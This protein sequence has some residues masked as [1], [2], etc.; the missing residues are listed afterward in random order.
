MMLSLSHTLNPGERK[1]WVWGLSY[2]L[3]TIINKGSEWP[4][5][6]GAGGLDAVGARPWALAP[7]A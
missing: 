2:L 3:S 4:R 7:N 5:L 6:A 1:F